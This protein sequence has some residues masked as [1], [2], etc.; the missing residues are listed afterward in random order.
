MT[1]TISQARRPAPERPESPPDP[2]PTT[3]FRRSV[4]DL[5]S[6]ELADRLARAWVRNERRLGE[7]DRLDAAVAGARRRLATSAVGRGLVEAHLARL[8]ARRAA[9]SAAARDDAELAEESCREWDAR[10]AP[11][12]AVGS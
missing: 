9:C 11:R 3:P 12:R 4:R 5:D 6:F 10:R 1:P 2:A 7:L 8:L